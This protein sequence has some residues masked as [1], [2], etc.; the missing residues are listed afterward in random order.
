MTNVEVVQLL[1]N[2][3]TFS[4]ISKEKNVCFSKLKQRILTIR[5]MSDC[6]NTSHLVATYFRK[7][8]IN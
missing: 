3:Y 7:G 1:A 4:Q 8:L 6:K 2:G 5:K